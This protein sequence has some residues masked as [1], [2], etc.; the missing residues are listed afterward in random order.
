MFLTKKVEH[1]DVWAELGEG[2]LVRVSDIQAIKRSS[3]SDEY[4]HLFLTGGRDYLVAGSEREVFQKIQN[5]CREAAEKV[6]E[7][8]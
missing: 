1:A 2:F 3:S 8:G 4:C 5:A 7:S 6:G